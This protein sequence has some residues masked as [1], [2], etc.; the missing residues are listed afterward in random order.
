MAVK[1]S[2]NGKVSTAAPEVEAENDAANPE[3][4]DLSER[5]RKNA[6]KQL[7]TGAT[8]IRNLSKEQ[9]G[10]VSAEAERLAQELEQTANRLTRP[11]PETLEAKI[12]QMADLFGGNQWGAAITAF[13]TGLILG[14]L[15][16][17][18]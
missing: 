13:V 4:L 3:L 10:A 7:R 5:A 15:M 9:D 1:G 17:R 12:D 8:R 16:R 18:K 14:L 6:A 2:S 11:E